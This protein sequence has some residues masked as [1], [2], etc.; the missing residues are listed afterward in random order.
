MKMAPH[1]GSDGHSYDAMPSVIRYEWTEDGWNLRPTEHE[2][3]SPMRHMQFHP[4][5]RAGLQE[6]ARDTEGEPY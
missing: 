3:V 4:V 6:Q 5:V 2:V 1:D